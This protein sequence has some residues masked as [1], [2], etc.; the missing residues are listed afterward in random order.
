MAS[1]RADNQLLIR[2]FTLWKR[3]IGRKGRAWR[4]VVF[5][6]K[7]VMW[8]VL[9]L[10]G[11]MLVAQQ[12]L[13][14]GTVMLFLSLLCA[15]SFDFMSGCSLVK[16]DTDWP[17][18]ERK[19]TISRFIFS[20]KAEGEFEASDLPTLISVIDEQKTLMDEKVRNLRSLMTDVVA[21]GLFATICTQ[22]M[23][24]NVLTEEGSIQ[25]TVGSILLLGMALVALVVS[26][27]IVAQHFLDECI[28]MSGSDLSSC[29]EA[30]R[31]ASMSCFQDCW[32]TAERIGKH[33]RHV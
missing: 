27:A 26:I 23:S 2:C 29:K 13:D 24:I 17:S 16:Q 33:M 1:Q 9:T 14:I 18:D 22:A 5:V 12:L 8:I 3:D 31:L 10:V 32:M 25:E 28:W 15:M 7:L 20:L 11:A 30:L 6:V 19:A 4:T 21:A